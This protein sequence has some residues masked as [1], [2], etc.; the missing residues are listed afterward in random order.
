MIDI[1]IACENYDRVASLASGAVKVEGCSARILKLH[2]E[3]LFF[4]AFHNHEF[5]V[6]ELSLSSYIMAT[7][8][9]DFPYIA[10]PVFPSRVFRHSGIYINTDTGISKPSD[11]RGRMVGVP[12][13][14]MTAALW[15]KGMLSD[16]YGVGPKDV[17]WRSGGQ[18]EAGREE[19]IKL[20]LPEG[21][22]VA[23][24]PSTKTLNG[25][26]ENGEI[27]ALISARAPSCLGTAKNVARLFPNYRKAE[28]DY[29][30]K[31][32]IFP[33]MHVVGIRRDLAEK[34]P[35]LPSSVFK[36]FAQSKANC[37]HALQEVGALLITLP[38]IVAEYEET[39][40][41]MGEDFWPYGVEKNR[42][43][44]EA[45][46]RYSYEQGL[47]EKKMEL[48]DL[49]HPNTTQQSKL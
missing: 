45:M 3:E 5:D 28:Q 40:R 49:F 37:M 24:I 43:V 17:K 2:A 36:A 35:W 27:D 16:E 10:I 48:V 14:Q 34:Y 30:K 23:P 1:T 18:E 19:K 7:S 12:E 41:L 47:C 15:I 9:G 6:C 11:L 29:F 46:L 13:Y 32:G 31:T 26:L 8:R 38:W 21:F 20:L 39:T 4:R 33:I 42:H 25:M 44:I 22:D